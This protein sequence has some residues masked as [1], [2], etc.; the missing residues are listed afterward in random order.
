MMSW[1][2]EKEDMWYIIWLCVA[3]LAVYAGMK[4][5]EKVEY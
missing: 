1:V 2:K 4:V 3:T 5:A